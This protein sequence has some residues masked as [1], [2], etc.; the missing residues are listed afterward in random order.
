[1]PDQEIIGGSLFI[2]GKLDTDLIEKINKRIMNFLSQKNYASKEEVVNAITSYEGRDLNEEEISSIL[3]VLIFDEKILN[4]KN[5][6]S[7]NQ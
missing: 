3:N 4:S 2:D 5:L 6:F 7:L 1:M